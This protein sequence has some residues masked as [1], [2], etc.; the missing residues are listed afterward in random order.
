[1][2]GMKFDLSKASIGDL[3]Q[4]IGQLSEVVNSHVQSSLDAVKAAIETG[5]AEV[6]QQIPANYDF[7]IRLSG[8][9]GKFSLTVFKFAPIING[10]PKPVIATAASATVTPTAV[11]TGIQ[12]GT[13]A[14]GKFQGTDALTKYASLKNLD[15]SAYKEADGKYKDGTN[16]FR[17]L[18]ELNPAWKGV[19]NDVIVSQIQVM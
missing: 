13:P 10:Q 17:V 15:I 9:E 5:L 16:A 18:K 7:D 4:L 12:N 19:A 1:M 14:N 2:S 6:D 11:V 3:R 8:K